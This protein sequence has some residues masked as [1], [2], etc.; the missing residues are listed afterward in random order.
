M[1]RENKL[2]QGALDGALLAILLILSQPF[3][4]LEGLIPELTSFLTSIPLWI[5][6]LLFPRHLTPLVEGLA[7]L[8]YFI[9]VGALVG[10]AF[11]RKRLWGWLFVV[12]LAMHH[13]AIYEQ[14]NRQMG[15]VVQTVLNLFHWS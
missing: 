6:A 9:L 1:M 3:Q 4:P 14:L 2:R 10:V 7:V 11:E 8:I 15:E 12:A 13:Y 5:A